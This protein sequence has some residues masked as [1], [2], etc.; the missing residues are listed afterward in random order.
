MRCVLVDSLY[1]SEAEKTGIGPEL[2]PPDGGGSPHKEGLRTLW[3]SKYGPR[4][5]WETSWAWAVEVR[6]VEG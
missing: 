3:E 1:E 4:Y 5:P 6:R 2:V